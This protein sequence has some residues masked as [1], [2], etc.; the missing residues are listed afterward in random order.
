MVL[1]EL[2]MQNRMDKRTFHLSSHFWRNLETD[3]ETPL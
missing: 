3:K 1:L 2:L